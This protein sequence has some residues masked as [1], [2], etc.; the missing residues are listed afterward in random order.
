MIPLVL[1]VAVITAACFFLNA[2]FAFAIA[3]PGPP[4][5]AGFNRARSSLTVVLGLGAAV[6]LC[7]GVFTVVFPAGG[8]GG[9]PS[10]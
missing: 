1:A 9:S 5:S 10:R 8:R 7:L 6:G 2:V 4:V 3:R